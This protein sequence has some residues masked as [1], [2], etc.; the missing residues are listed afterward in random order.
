MN[1]G[2]LDI[3]SPRPY[4]PIAA[5][6]LTALGIDVAGLIKKTQHPHFYEQLGLQRGV[7]FDQ[8]TFGADKLVVGIGTTPFKQL[9]ASAPLSAQAREQIIRIQ[10][11]R[12]DYLPGL[13]SEEKKQRLSRI[14]YQAFLR[15]LVTGRAG[16][17]A[18]STRRTPRA[19]G[20]WAST[21]CLR[22]IAGAF[23]LPGFQ[24]MHL[25]KGS[26]ERMGYTP[27]GYEDTGGSLHLH[28]PDGNATIARLLVRDLIPQA[29]PGQGIG[30]YRHRAS[31][32]CA[33]RPCRNARPIAAE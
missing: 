26:I 2:T 18:T 16:G 13:T 3:D 31:Q 30:E 25:A 7:F 10:E 20:G 15:D 21:L 23:G 11:Q 8:E 32:L 6:L 9:L 28:F 5:G 19:N 24:G 14:S 1:G 29:V 33:A 27:A 22:S 17:T 12:V 4:G